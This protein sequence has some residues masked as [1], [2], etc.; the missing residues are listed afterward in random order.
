[1]RTLSVVVTLAGPLFDRVETASDPVSHRIE[2]E[3]AAGAEEW[4][5]AV[6]PVVELVPAAGPLRGQLVRVSVDGRPCLIPASVSAEALAYAA[7]S[8]EVPMGRE[9][10]A[11]VSRPDGEGSTSPEQV[12]EMLALVCRSAVASRP[13]TLVPEGDP[14][15]ELLEHG[16]SIAGEDPDMLRAEVLAGDGL[17]MLDRLTTPTLELLV[18][19][20][21]LEH[22]TSAQDG[23][24]LFAYMR[25]GLFV[26]LGL[27]IPS[28]HMSLDPS[29]RPR[30]FA[31]RV[32][33][34]RTMPRIGLTPGTIYVND[35]P[36]RLALMNVPGELSAN[37]S[38]SKPGTIVSDTHKMR[39]ED[40]GLTVW[41]PFA[42][43]IL[44]LAAE[45][46]AH[47]RTFVPPREVRA[48]LE[49]LQQ[50]LPASSPTIGE[51]EVATLLT[52]VLRD[53]AAE[54]V[55]SRNLR[56]V[57]DLLIRYAVAPELTDG[58][59][60]TSFVRAGL[61][62]VIGNTAARGTDAIVVYL[63]EKTFEGELHGAGG[64]IDPAV[65]EELR[66][67]VHDEMS[68]LPPTAQTP[69]L[70]TGQASRAA[71]REAICQEFPAVRVLSY[72]DIPAD[73]NVQPV[74]RISR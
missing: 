43:Y 28:M 40:A 37:P 19:P 11:M 9:L 73:F 56:Y 61:T 16:V 2:Q 65:A 71:V 74:A 32:N 41:D 21:Y 5:V 66:E 13:D 68:H 64:R 20:A 6:H 70:L 72:A 7:G 48:M 39:L 46:R 25:S 42:Y 36:E 14:L 27:V 4:G 67:A 26:E 10:V 30:G 52:P 33:S 59:D 3:I 15:A 50:A 62:D 45:L 38:T 69:S 29:L 35:T 22:L 44:A 18:E 51:T 12:H 55:S 1:M 60:P 54:R 58:L 23:G 53:L 8:A 49:R 47:A 31:V 63:L 57:V 34:V 17:A 24:E